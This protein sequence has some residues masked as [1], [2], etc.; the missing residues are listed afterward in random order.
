LSFP[1]AQK[2]RKLVVSWPSGRAYYFPA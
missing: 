2:E 1:S